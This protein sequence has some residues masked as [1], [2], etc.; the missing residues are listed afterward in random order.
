MVYSASSTG[1]QIHQQMSVMHK[2][3]LPP[4]PNYDG[5]HGGPV[6]KITRISE[7]P[8]VIYDNVELGDDLLPSAR[9]SGNSQP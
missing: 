8:N 4:Q 5:G 9:E 2:F 6:Q 7:L 3:D 1:M